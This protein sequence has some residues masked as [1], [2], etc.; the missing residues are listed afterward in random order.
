MKRELQQAYNQEQDNIQRYLDFVKWEKKHPNKVKGFI[1]FTTIIDDIVIETSDC[2]PPVVNY[3][4]L[5]YNADGVYCIIGLSQEAAE[6]MKEDREYIFM[7]S[8]NNYDDEYKRAEIQLNAGGEEP[9]EFCEM[10]ICG[11][12]YK[13]AE[14]AKLGHERICEFIRKNG[15]EN[16]DDDDE[17]FVKNVIEGR[18]YK[19]GL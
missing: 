11:A 14:E 6:E 1:P 5:G 8:W 19:N 7:T 15:F 10:E 16:F 4:A 12:K 3:L 18:R 9:V 2:R 17:D 13:T